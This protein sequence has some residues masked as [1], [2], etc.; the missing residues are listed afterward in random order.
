MAG[1]EI[2][3]KRRDLR[4]FNTV[5]DEESLNYKT[6]HVDVT[7]ELGVLPL[8]NIADCFDPT[9]P[10]RR[11]PDESPGKNFER[12]TVSIASPPR[13]A[14]PAPPKQ[15]PSTQ[16]LQGRKNRA[17]ME[18]NKA[19]WGYTKVALLFFVSLLVTW[20]RRPGYS[21]KGFKT[22]LSLAV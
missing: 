22:D 16:S 8:G 13:G 21:S 1:R 10:G 18:A 20:V 4:V 12:Y 9:R 11:V 6:T 19:A 3:H 17:A 5:E 2:F 14:R 15:L 7:S